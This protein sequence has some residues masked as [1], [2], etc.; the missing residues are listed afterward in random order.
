MRGVHPGRRTCLAFCTAVI[1]STVGCASEPNKVS[2]GTL[3]TIMD[4]SHGEVTEISEVEL[5]SNAAIGTIIGGLVGLF[6][7]RGRAFSTQVAGTAGGAALG[8]LGTRFLEGPRRANAYTVRRLDGSTVEVVTEPTGI[9]VG[10]CVAIEEGKT[11]TNLRH[12]SDMLCESRA[13]HPVEAELAR[14]QMSEA[15]ACD[16]AKQAILEAN[17][18]SELEGAVRKARVLCEH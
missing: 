13:A 3:N 2:R 16:E 7:T 12:V 10:D 9:R 17:T 11:T 8:G 5:Q 18:E 15:M 4:I 6:V 14:I 1:V